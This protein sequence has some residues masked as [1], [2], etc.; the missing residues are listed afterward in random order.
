MPAPKKSCAFMGGL[1][2]SISSYAGRGVHVNVFVN[3]LIL[4]KMLGR[5]ILL[6]QLNDVLHWV[7]GTSG[8]S[9]MPY[10][11]TRQ[12]GEK[13]D[14]YMWSER[15]QFIV[16]RVHGKGW[17]TRAGWAQRRH[18]MKTFTHMQS[19]KV[20]G[21]DKRYRRES[22]LVKT[23]LFFNYIISKAKHSEDWKLVTVIYR[24]N[25]SSN[26]FHC[27]FCSYFHTIQTVLNFAL[28]EC[29]IEEEFR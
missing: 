29:L 13:H 21:V 6:F 28:R 7:E 14:G 22:H 25:G 4:S 24:D 3:F 27:N 8:N 9:L 20:P 5:S 17:E 16:K 19:N 12:A 23:L 2:R 1:P 18:F 26:L 10:I 11:W 15:Q